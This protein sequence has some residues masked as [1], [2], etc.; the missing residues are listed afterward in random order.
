MTGT[1][2]GVT[3]EDNWV[4]YDININ[5][6]VYISEICVDYIKERKVRYK[7]IPLYKRITLVIHMR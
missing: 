5:E 7:Y 6:G 4:K 1:E 3:Y 2:I